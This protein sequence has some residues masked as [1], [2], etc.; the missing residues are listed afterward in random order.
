MKKYN[1]IIQK[2]KLF[3]ALAFVG[4]IALGITVQ[5]CSKEE[6]EPVVLDE[7]ILNSSELEEFIVAGAD[8]Q[9]SLAIFTDGLNQIDFSTLE[10]ITHAE[11]KESIHLPS[12]FWKSIRIEEK[13]QIFNE[14]KE[15]LIRKIPQFTACRE[16]IQKKYLNACV[17]NSVNVQGEFL[18]L[19]IKSSRPLLKGGTLESWSGEDLYALIYFLVSWMSSSNYVELFIL[20]YTNG[21]Y[22][23][24]VDDR[25][26]PLKC[27]ASFN[28]INDTWYHQG[29]AVSWV[30]HTHSNDSCASPEDKYNATNKTPGLPS[31]I[32]YQGGYYGYNF[33]D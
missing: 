14:K 11:G 10:V 4:M 16:D 31:Y 2:I 25:N 20:S 1:Y 22:G 29:N 24:W 5:S 19:G 28:R 8:L 23:T 17:N 18:K 33:C 13:L 32:Y 6:Y 26:T 7:E 12:S 21:T 3:L 9:Q 30:A 15:V 27:H